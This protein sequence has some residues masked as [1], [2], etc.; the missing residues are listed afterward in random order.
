MTGMKMTYQ[1]SMAP[2]IKEL[3]SAC[4]NNP[5]ALHVA[6]YDLW[7]VEVAPARLQAASDEDIETD[8]IA[9][10]LEDARVRAK[11]HAAYLRTSKIRDDL[12]VSKSLE[13][14]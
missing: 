5:A 13:I 14:V 12:V 9:G 8:I 11:S 1:K 3:R 2:I 4:D 10:I 6:L 7:R